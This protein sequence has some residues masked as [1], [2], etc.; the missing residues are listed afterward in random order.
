MSLATDLAAQ[1]ALR[2]WLIDLGS[3]ALLQFLRRTWGHQLRSGNAPMLFAPAE[4]TTFFAPAGWEEAEYRPILDEA[5]RLQRAPRM[6]WLW[7]LLGLFATRKRRDE[8]KRFSGVVLLK[9]E[10]QET[11]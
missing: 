7:R 4:G 9:R 6:A 11:R 1:P 3:P 2:W 10:S 5:F 8:F